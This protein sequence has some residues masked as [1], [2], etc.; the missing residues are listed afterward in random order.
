MQQAGN[1][2]SVLNTYFR[3]DSARNW[4]GWGSAELDGLIKRLNVEFD[5]TGATTC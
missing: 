5:A 1:P 2:M 3:T 4:G